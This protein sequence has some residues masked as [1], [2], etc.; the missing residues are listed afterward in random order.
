MKRAEHNVAELRVRQD[1]AL[2]ARGDDETC[3]RPLLRP[4]RAITATGADDAW[5]G[6]GIQHAAQDMITNARKILHASTADQN[7]ECS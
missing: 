4:L 5:A 6:P 7:H 1:F 3:D 2:F